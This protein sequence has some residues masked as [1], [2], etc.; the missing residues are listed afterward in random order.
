MVQGQ[1]FMHQLHCFRK[2]YLLESTFCLLEWLNKQ[3]LYDLAPHTKLSLLDALTNS[4]NPAFLKEN[5]HDSTDCVSAEKRL[6]LRVKCLEN[7]SWKKAWSCV[8]F[9]FCG[10]YVWKIAVS[11][12]SFQQCHSKRVD[13]GE[14][15]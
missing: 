10:G 15:H 8:I 12:V 9:L 5:K 4:T 11:R 1:V 7:Q 2:A 13:V 14:K 6:H 3:S